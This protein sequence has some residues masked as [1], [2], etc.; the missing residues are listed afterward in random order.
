[1]T[2]CIDHGRKGFGLGY[3]TAWRVRDGKRVTTTLHRAVFY[4]YTGT[5]PEV[6]RH[7]CD[8]ARCINTLHMVAGTQVD[9]MADM[10]GRGRAGDC[11]NFSTNNG[12]CVLTDAQVAE[13]RARYETGNGMALS[14]EYGISRSQ[15]GRIVKGEQR[16]S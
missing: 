5:W 7:T 8:N 6:V 9:N 14:R 3:A 12:R 4:D 10:H 15:I 13:I 2:P 16:A 11:R 1:M